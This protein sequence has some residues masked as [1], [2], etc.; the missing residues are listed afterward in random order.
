MSEMKDNGK[1]GRDEDGYDSDVSVDPK[2][3]LSKCMSHDY[4][5]LNSEDD[6]YEY[7]SCMKD[8]TTTQLLDDFIL[9][10]RIN[11][12]LTCRPSRR[13]TKSVGVL[14]YT[15]TCYL[16]SKIIILFF[17]ML[18]IFSVDIGVSS[19]SELTELWL[20]VEK[21]MWEIMT[22]NSTQIMSDPPS[23][24]MVGQTTG[25]RLGDFIMAMSNHNNDIR[26]GLSYITSVSRG[27]L[28]RSLIIGDISSLLTRNYNVLEVDCRAEKIG[29]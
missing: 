24:E 20:L 10:S 27:E 11:N 29:F 16:S 22:T 23:L 15:T 8:N 18:R 25:D 7:I 26:N 21:M 1:R 19:K 17:T 28:D 5:L 4:T 2:R 14:W 9:K 12:I 13:N 3:V 6:I